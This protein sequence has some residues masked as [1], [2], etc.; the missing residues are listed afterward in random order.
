M[1]PTP[2]LDL[3]S[4]FPSYA[5]VLGWGL[6]L[7]HCT[8]KTLLIIFRI[9]WNWNYWGWFYLATFD[10]KQLMGILIQLRVPWISEYHEPI[11]ESCRVNL[12]RGLCSGLLRLEVTVNVDF[13][14]WPFSPA[15]W[16]G[17]TAFLVTCFVVLP[18]KANWIGEFPE[19]SG[20]WNQEFFVFSFLWSGSLFWTIFPAS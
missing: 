5:W 9:A 20:K 11:Q 13:I 16:F 2:K 19:G 4:V 15:L 8:A 1:S 3:F 12:G 10:M 7:I 14:F 17:G 6:K 18:L